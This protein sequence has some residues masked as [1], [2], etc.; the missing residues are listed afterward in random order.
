[1]CLGATNGGPAQ[2]NMHRA[3]DG[4]EGMLG[5]E[6]TAGRGTQPTEGWTVLAHLASKPLL[7]TGES[8]WCDPGG[9]A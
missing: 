8:T 2:L 1:M 4:I 3:G 9:T 7:V 6:I 5:A